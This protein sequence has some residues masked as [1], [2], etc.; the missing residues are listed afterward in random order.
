MFSALHILSNICH[1]HHLLNLLPKSSDFSLLDQILRTM[2]CP[3]L[4]LCDVLADTVGD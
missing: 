2:F 1:E 4:L 3:K